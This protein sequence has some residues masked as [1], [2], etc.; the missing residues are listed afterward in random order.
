MAKK[1]YYSILEIPRNASPE[2]IKKAYRKL[3][4]K[5]HPDKNPGNKVAEDRFKE[6][7]E[8]YEVLRDPKRKQMYDQFGHA[9][10]HAGA[11]GFSGAAGAGGPNPFEG[12]DFS[13]GG[14]GGGTRGG[15]GGA[16][17]SESF[18]DAFGDFF[19]DVFGG[20]AGAA[21]GRQRTAYNRGR[22]ADLRYTLSITLEEAAAGTEKTISF[23]RQRNGHEDTA[24][25]AV[26]IP[27]GVKE[28]QRLKL[29]GEG[30]GGPSS[31]GDLYVIVHLQEHPLF[32]RKD[33]D[34]YLDLPITFTDAIL[35]TTL[36]IPTLT[37]LA[38][39][40]IPPQTHPGQTFRLKSKGFPE[41][42]GYGNG[43][44]LVK[45]VVDIPND[46]SENE[47]QALKALNDSAQ[48]KSP[49]VNEFREKMRKVLKAR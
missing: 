1:D 41:V 45:I 28:G 18:Q 2:D 32:T 23:I 4:M 49:L 31:A 11:H 12:F 39:L 14:F 47:K 40:R 36:E 7:S 48:N 5:F 29:K 13:F 44:M 46:L 34:V 30:D 42:G 35:G 26:T 37:G 3:A 43:D 21:A 20:A 10:A 27:S 19:G 6:A 17:G 25:L 38:Q 33:S 16:R 8:A 24:K 15:A 9:G 22:G